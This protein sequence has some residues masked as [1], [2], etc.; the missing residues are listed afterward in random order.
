LI[1]GSVHAAYHV[2]DNY[3]PA[4]IEWYSGAEQ[5]NYVLKEH[6]SAA[7]AAQDSDGNSYV[8]FTIG[9]G[10][11]GDGEA[12]TI[13]LYYQ[14]SIKDDSYWKNLKNLE[15]TYT[16]KIEWGSYSDSQTTTVHREVKN[17]SKTGAQVMEN[18]N[19]TNRIRYT[20]AVNPA[21][22]DLAKGSDV[23][24]LKD[25]LTAGNSASVLP[26]T[27]SLYR[28]DVE[29]ADHIGEKITGG[30]LY[31]YDDL[32]H[33]LSFTLPDSTPCI[34]TYEYAIDRGATS[35]DISVSNSASLQGSATVTD[36]NTVS[37]KESSSYATAARQKIV[38]YKVDANDYTHVLQGAAFKLEHYASGAWTTDSANL[39][40]DNGGQIVFDLTAANALT[41]NTLYRLTELSAP[42]GYEKSTKPY[43]FVRKAKDATDYATW[44]T[45]YSG[46]WDTALQ[47]ADVR[48]LPVTGGA[49]YVPNT[50]TSLT[51]QKLWRNRDGSTLTSPTGSVSMTLY[52]QK[53]K[54]DA[55]TVT[56]N[57]DNL[58]WTLKKSVPVAKGSKL[59]IT[60]EG[61]GDSYLYYS[62]TDKWIQTLT[63]DSVASDMTIN[64]EASEDGKKPYGV[65]FSDYDNPVSVTDGDAEK[66]ESVTLDAGNNWSHTW[67]AL[68]QSD[69]SG[70][71]YYYTVQEE[72]SDGCQVAYL[73]NSGIPSGTITVTNTVVSY[74]LPKTGGTGIYPLILGGAGMTGAALT[75]EIRRKRRGGE[76]SD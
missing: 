70:N 6:L 28:Y 38:I 17:L 63:L 21:G 36:G 42:G 75:L 47:Q 73:N 29:K 3:E 57:V 8:D 41:T 74:M 51:V 64:L 67:S 12:H 9:S 34:V 2:N 48:F 11:A 46:N 33:T 25:T 7:D 14:L 71:P 68:T 58:G 54:V 20:V 39:T 37:L 23:L 27:I 50:F 35:G 55:C 43:Y 45:M 65:V 49:I 1:P 56:V 31:T 16:N 19:L 4:S 66:V 61:L 5:K 59:K 22:N 62:T 76:A 18:G 13:A 44:Q 53:T 52:R 15:K 26:D 10:Y 32:T 72:N 60:F 24:T 40:T 30:W 69:A